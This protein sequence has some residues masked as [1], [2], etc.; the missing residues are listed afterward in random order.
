MAYGNELIFKELT[1]IWSL[2]QELIYEFAE[3]HVFPALGP[4]CLIHHWCASYA[5]LPSSV[6][7]LRLFFL[8]CVVLLQLKGTVPMFSVCAPIN[9]NPSASL[10]FLLFNHIKLFYVLFFSFKSLVTSLFVQLFCNNIFTFSFQFFFWNKLNK[11][12]IFKHLTIG[13][14]LKIVTVQNGISLK[15]WW[16]VTISHKFLVIDKCHSSCLILNFPIYELKRF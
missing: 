13:H 5:P 12:P 2:L 3:S 4:T 6:S 9:H 15:T 11:H 7:A 8:S 1:R 10:F 16:L 14:T